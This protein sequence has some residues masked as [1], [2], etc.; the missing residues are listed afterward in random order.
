VTTAA[1]RSRAKPRERRTEHDPDAPIPDRSISSMQMVVEHARAAVR[2]WH[3]E[4]EDQARA[5]LREL[6]AEAQLLA[7][8]HPL[9]LPSL[10][11]RRQLVSS[12]REPT[13]RSGTS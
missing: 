2:A 6:S 5:Q 4:D 1:Q 3:D 11:A 12:E 8:M 7:C 9:P 10:L 13:P